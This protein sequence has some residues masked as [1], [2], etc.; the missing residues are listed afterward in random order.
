LNKNKNDAGAWTGLG[1]AYFEGKDIN[2]AIQS[3]RKALE[4]KPQD[5]LALGNLGYVYFKEEKWEESLQCFETVQSLNP[6]D[7]RANHYV[8]KLKQK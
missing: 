5:Q 8:H 1:N 3:Y 7:A 2:K 6:T 4:I